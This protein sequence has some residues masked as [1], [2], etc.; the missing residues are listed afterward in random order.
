MASVKGVYIL[1]WASKHVKMS[2]CY[3]GHVKGSLQG[4]V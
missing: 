2:I 4:R 1:G 3:S